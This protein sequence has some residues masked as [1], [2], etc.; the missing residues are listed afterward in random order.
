VYNT[1]QRYFALS[2]GAE[3]LSKADDVYPS[4]QW[5]HH[6]HAQ[7]CQKSY[8]HEEPSGDTLLMLVN[9]MIQTSIQIRN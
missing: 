6:V 2:S 3:R 7:A 8:L 9:V 1:L 4:A 5:H